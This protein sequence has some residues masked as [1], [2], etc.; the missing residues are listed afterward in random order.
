MGAFSESKKYFEH[1]TGYTKPL[2]YESWSKLDLELKAS[3]LFLQF[4]SVIYKAYRINKTAI[5]DECECVEVVV[6]HLIKNV[7]KILNDSNRFTE[8]Y[9]YR[10]A[11]NAINS[12]CHIR[13]R[14]KM[15]LQL[16]QSNIV[17]DEKDNMEFD[18]FDIIPNGDGDAFD[19]LERKALWEDVYRL[20]EVQTRI[21]EYLMYGTK[22]TKKQI[23][24]FDAALSALKLKFDRY[25]Q[26]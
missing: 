17:Y 22:L 19:E 24:E 25:N 12:V 11:Y 21:L 7:P 20:S 13:V 16:E 4:Y 10:I 23:R 26:K 3:I 5:T 8:S 15:R 9:I 2:T 18:A 14:D 1:F 6:Q